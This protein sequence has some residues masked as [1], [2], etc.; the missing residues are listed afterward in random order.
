MKIKELITLLEAYNPELPVCFFMNDRQE[1]A[2]ID[3]DES[4]E[5]VWDEN[6]Q[7]WIL[8]L[9]EN[10]DSLKYLLARNV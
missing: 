8:S 3:D 1:Y 7:K 4:I 2:E 6:N 9:N 5:K 10:D